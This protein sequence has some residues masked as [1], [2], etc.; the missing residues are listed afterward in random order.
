MFKSYINKEKHLSYIIYQHK[1]IVFSNETKRKGGNIYFITILTILHCLYNCTN[2]KEKLHQL[3]N[4][5]VK[6]KS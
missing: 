1:S 5:K 6:L 4:R 2:I 3:S